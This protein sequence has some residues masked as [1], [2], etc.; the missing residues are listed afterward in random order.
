MRR[1]P[2]L[3]NIVANVW[4]PITRGVCTVNTDSVWSVATS[5]I[6]FLRDFCAVYISR[7]Y[8]SRGNTAPIDKMTEWLL[9]RL[10]FS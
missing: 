10:S 6:L 4:K 7:E 8:I 1:Q 3:A 5:V 9:R 2:F